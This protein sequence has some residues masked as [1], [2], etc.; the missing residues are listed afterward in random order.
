MAIRIRPMTPEEVDTIRRLAPTSAKPVGMVSWTPMIW[1]ANQG[2]Q[3]PA[4]ARER[5]LR[6]ATIRSWLKRD[7]C[8]GLAGL[9]EAPRPGCP[10]TWAAAAVNEV[11]ATSL[12]TPQALGCRSPGGRSIDWPP[13]CGRSREAEQALTH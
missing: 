13:T 7:N 6:P 9:Q 8:Q 2:Q 5:R 3:V 1:L 12:T 10:V 4:I 11:S